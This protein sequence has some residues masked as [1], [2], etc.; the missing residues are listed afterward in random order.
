MRGL[1][2][3]TTIVPGEGVEKGSIHSCDG[4]RK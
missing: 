2:G 3:R 4:E 1:N